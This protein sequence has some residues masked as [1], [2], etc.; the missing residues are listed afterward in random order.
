MNINTQKGFSVLELLLVIT[1]IGIIAAVGIQSW[2][3]GKRAVDNGA[4]YASMRSVAS[5]QVSFFSQN[6]RFARLDEVNT[7]HHSGLGTPSGTSLIR[8]RFVFS[9]SPV[10]PTD[11]ELKTAYTIIAT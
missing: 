4:V 2:L 9:M 5:T 1:I 3:K 6:Q 11:T 7:L 8:G 10:A